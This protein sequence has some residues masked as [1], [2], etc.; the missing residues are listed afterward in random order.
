M[1]NVRVLHMADGKAIESFAQAFAKDHPSLRFGR[2]AVSGGESVLRPGHGGMRIFWLYRGEGEV[3]LPEG[4]RTKE[5]DG[6]ALPHEYA[7]EPITPELGDALATIRDGIDTVAEE[8]RVPVDAILSRWQGGRYTGDYANDLWKL[9][10]LPRPWANSAAVESALTAL[11]PLCAGA[12][13]SRKTADGW[14]LVMEGDQLVVAPGGELR[15]R[16]DFACLTL[17][18]MDRATSHVPAATRLRFLKDTSGGCNFDFDP[19]RRLPLTWYLDGPGDNEE[20]VNFANSH[21]VNIA[22]ETSPS[23]FHPPFAIGG[24]SAQN[25]FYLVLDPA[26]YGLDTHGREAS[27]I[28]YPDLHDLSQFDVHPLEPGNFV[29]IPPGVGHR[30]IDVFVNVIT[31]PGFKPN[32]EYYM[33]RDIMESGRGAPYNPGLVGLKNYDAIASLIGSPR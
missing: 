33:D 3:L 23:H 16:G 18:K 6:G 11:Y 19:F 20:G 14:E 27:V 31:V 26:A 32:N 7:A 25:E 12:G 24:G 10:H 15:V 13:F 29:H 2:F 4:F 1:S 5:G 21:V 9:E 8:A 22:K 30:G 28:T 17:E